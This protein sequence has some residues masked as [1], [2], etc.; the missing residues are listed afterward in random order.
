MRQDQ[1]NSRTRR[2]AFDAYYK[3]N[4]S[5]LKG[6]SLDEA[7]AAMQRQATR[8]SA[9]DRETNHGLNPK[10]AG[11]QQAIQR[12]IQQTA[13]GSDQNSRKPVR[14]PGRS[15]LHYPVNK[16]LD[17]TTG[18]PGIPNP[19]SQKDGKTPW[20]RLNGELSNMNK[21]LQEAVNKNPLAHSGNPLANKNG[22]TPYDRLI[23]R[24]RSK[25]NQ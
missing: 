11:R 19:F 15:D 1:G 6:K 9:A 18:R 2:Q 25:T 3:S 12:R 7:Y 14:T 10:L 4:P 20:Q 21:N 22:Q 24:K 23:G 17:K 5:K 16:N 13:E 8:N